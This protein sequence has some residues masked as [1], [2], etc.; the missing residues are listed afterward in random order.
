M[1]SHTSF[2]KLLP[3]VPPFTGGQPRPR[4]SH[5]NILEQDG[6]LKDNQPDPPH[7]TGGETEAQQGK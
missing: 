1:K 7:L 5:D 3:E 6:T 2:L 4:T